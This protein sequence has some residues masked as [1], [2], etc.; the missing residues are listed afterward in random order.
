MVQ[1]LE[2]VRVEEEVK[3]PPGHAPG[4]LVVES[5]RS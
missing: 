5:F 2:D 4:G 3:Q 1:K